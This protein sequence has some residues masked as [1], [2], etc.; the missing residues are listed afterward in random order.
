M[1]RR[2]R[3]IAEHKVCEI[4]PRAREGLPLPPTETT[5]ILLK[6]ILARAQRDD[7]VE[8]H[9]FVMMG[10]HGHIHASPDKAA[11]L[12]L[13]YCEV[14]KKT[15]D[16]LRAMMGLGSLRLWEDRTGVMMIDGLDDVINRLIYIFCNPTKADLVD[17]I[18]EYCGL[19]TWRDFTTCEANVNAEVHISAPWHPVASLPRLPTNRVLSKE[20]DRRM[21][22]Q[23]CASEEAI[24]HTLVIKPLAFLAQFG[25]TDP[26]EIEE[27]RQ[28]VIRRV[29]EQ[30]AE[31]RVKRTREKKAP[32]G[33]EK[34]QRQAYFKIHTPKEKGRKV[35]L[36]CADKVRRLELLQAFQSIFDRCKECYQMAKA[37]VAA[38]W[39]PGTFIPWIPPKECCSF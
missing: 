18:D 7:K 5:N 31:Y 32:L 2:P 23:L 11:N 15:T 33:A 1:A 35:F 16:T 17:S 28:T 19:N 25:I 9:N 14:Q 6:G 24:P 37:G 3:V 13:F 10:N 38:V 34:L 29:R 12:P 21:A 27:I 4:I 30:E 20:Q 36:I 22:E 8:L 26:V 39:P